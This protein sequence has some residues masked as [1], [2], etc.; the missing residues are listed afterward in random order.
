MP[1]YGKLATAEE[2]EL[3]LSSEL[4]RRSSYSTHTS[5]FE[6]GSQQDLYGRS[7]STVDRDGDK[8]AS[9]PRLGKPRRKNVIDAKNLTAVV[10]SII[11]LVAALTAVFSNEVSWRLGLTYQLVVSGFLLSVMNLCLQAV[12]SDLL[13]L[14]EARYGPSTL[15]NYNALLKWEPLSTDLHKAW[16]TVLIAIFALPIGL[17]AAYKI[18]V[19][20]HSTS[21]ID[22]IAVTGLQP[23]YGLFGL[24][25]L[26]PL[27]MS[28]GISLF[29]NA[30]LPFAVASSPAMNGNNIISEPTIPETIQTYGSNMVL[31]SKDSTAFLDL[32]NP[33]YVSSLQAHLGRDETY[34]ISASVYGTVSTR[35]DH[36]NSD[37]S[38]NSTYMQY[39]D[40]SAPVAWQN[41]YNLY[42]LVLFTNPGSGNQST[43]YLAI[44]PDDVAITVPSDMLSYCARIANYFTR[45]DTARYPCHGQWGV[46]TGSIELLHGSCSTE[47]LLPEKQNPIAAPDLYAAYSNWY[48][49]LLTELIGTFSSARMDS[50]WTN[51]TIAT[52]MAAMMW[53]RTVSLASPM[54]YPNPNDPDN[55]WLGLAA[56]DI[57]LVY[58][59]KDEVI[60]H[61]ETL[62][63]SYWLLLVFGIQPLLT[64]LGL[65]W[66]ALL[67]S[68]PIDRGLGLVSILAGIERDSLDVLSGASLSGELT[69]SAR[70]NIFVREDNVDG[71]SSIRYRV[72]TNKDLNCSRTLSRHTVYS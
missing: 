44:I 40:G 42:W 57:G 47:P 39:C 41:M 46:S 6:Q 13:I 26:Q 24:P 69:T 53:S 67:Y 30:T 45:Y 10:T 7:H 18:F 59:V 68:V 2:H 4:S 3:T 9:E 54:Q 25:G 12:L 65:V 56:G 48:M 29:F 72:G 61:R 28:T 63:K 34:N 33:Y 71:S 15:Q 51:T 20:G 36:F 43:G 11:V 50:A 52:G 58:Q 55:D 23:H 14:I 31:L 21:I 70:L 64:V 37:R 60:S 16:Q 19:G 27:G 5:G 49:P 35:V 22:S 8:K 32:P 17:S 66:M 62:L 38:S 1:A